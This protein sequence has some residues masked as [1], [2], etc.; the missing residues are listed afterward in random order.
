[1]ARAGVE[2]LAGNEFDL[3]VVGHAPISDA[4]WA[5]EI[6][7]GHMPAANFKSRSLRQTLFNGYPTQPSVGIGAQ[8]RVVWL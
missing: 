4:Q 2:L 6:A 7:L 1:M 3:I 8:P 5:K